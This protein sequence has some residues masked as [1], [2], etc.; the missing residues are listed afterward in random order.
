MS[1][2]ASIVNRS[3]LKNAGETPALLFGRDQGKPF[4]SAQGKRFGCAQDKP[5]DS[6]QGKPALLS[7]GRRGGRLRVL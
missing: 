2:F 7:D 6:A 1:R 5:F 3:V 4:R